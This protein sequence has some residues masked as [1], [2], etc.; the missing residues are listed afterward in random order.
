MTDKASEQDIQVFLADNPQWILEHDTLCRSFRFSD[1]VQAFGFMSQVA[2]I[3]E[4]MNHHPEWFNVYNRVDI[5][6]TTHDANGISE[7]DFALA[8]KINKLSGHA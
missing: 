2:L 7:K 4:R 5:K 6:L 1:F 8:C 3:A